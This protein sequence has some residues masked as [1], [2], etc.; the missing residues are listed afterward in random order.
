MLDVEDLGGITL[1]PRISF[2][3][4]N[5]FESPFIE[6]ASVRLCTPKDPKSLA[7]AIRSVVHD[8]ALQERLKLGALKL[9]HEWFSWENTRTRITEALEKNV[10]SIQ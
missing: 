9:A 4:K 2:E 7:E 1:L 8:A 6:N 3:Y 5:F 10:S